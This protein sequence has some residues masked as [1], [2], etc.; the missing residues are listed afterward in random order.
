MCKGD[1]VAL[2]LQRDQISVASHCTTLCP[3][4]HIR[5]LATDV[6]RVVSV[7]DTSSLS[8]R[9]PP[10]L[11][12]K[13]THPRCF[14]ECE[15]EKISPRGTDNHLGWREKPPGCKCCTTEWDWVMAPGFHTKVSPPV[16]M[17][18]HKPCQTSKGDQPC[19]HATR[20]TGLSQLCSALLFAT[21]HVR[22]VSNAHLNSMFY[23]NELEKTGL[24]SEDSE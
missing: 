4:R 2:R 15:E 14:Y 21:G 3:S 13:V 7:S 11:L 10:G 9:S 19:L 16:V 6:S 17:G 24:R 22:S 20:T 1:T 23:I 12:L 8:F 5:P 18:H